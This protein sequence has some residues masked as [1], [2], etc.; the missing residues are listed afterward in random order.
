[1]NKKDEYNPLLDEEFELEEEILPLEEL[2]A[3][4]EANNSGHR[5]NCN[6]DRFEEWNFFEERYYE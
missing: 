6:N 3:E 2:E 4:E 1:M 5:L